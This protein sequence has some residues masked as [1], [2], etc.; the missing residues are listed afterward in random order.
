MLLPFFYLSSFSAL[1]FSLNS[2]A[3]LPI[4]PVL[5]SPSWV[6]MSYDSGQILSS[7]NP[8]AE[9][10]PA[11][12]TKIM[13]AYVIAKELQLGHANITDTVIISNNAKSSNFPGSSL[14]QLKENQKVSVEDLL[15][16]LLISSGNDAAVALAEHLTGHPANFIQL[17]NNYAEQLGMSHTYFSNPHG[18]DSQ[19]QVTTASDMARLTQAMIQEFPDIYAFFKE[20]TFTYKKVKHINRNRLLW[21]T[22]LSIDGV[23][24]GYTSQAG[25][26]LI[27]S[28]EQQNQRLIAVV[29]GSKT[30]QIRQRES[31][32]LLLWG[33]RFFKNIPSPLNPTELD[34]YKVWYGNPSHVSIS[35]TGSVL[36]VP[37]HQ[38][39]PLRYE[40]KYKHFIDAPLEAGADIGEIHWYMGK[41]H[42]ASQPLQTNR[43]VE[44]G[45]WYQ[46]MLDR[47]WRPASEWITN[48][49]DNVNDSWNESLTK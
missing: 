5:T 7:K 23:K 48:M 35:P 15:K 37:R 26:N 49:K 46:V 12:L 9:R 22:Q 19:Q 2:W 4:A 30:P 17:M 40:V 41:K 27:S 28:S 10:A 24:T 6:L 13:S 36:T 44:R 38:K 21:D 25:Y 33:Y 43:L 32:K 39:S 45:Q 8:H 42:I 16:G 47:A 1:F 11:S 14:M 34:S 29:M 18:L 31:K 20:K 3:N